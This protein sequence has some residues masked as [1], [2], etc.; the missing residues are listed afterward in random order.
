MIIGVTAS[1]TSSTVIALNDV[2][3]TCISSSSVIRPGYSW[4]HVNGTVP[5]HASGQNTNMLTL[6]RVVPADEGQYY[7]TA[8]WYGHCAR[9]DNV[10]VMVEGNIICISN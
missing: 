2:T 1:P 6:H 10:M 7:C 4:H 3:L 8:S 9:S 5:S